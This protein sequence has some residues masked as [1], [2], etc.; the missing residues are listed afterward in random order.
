[1]KFQKK[2]G[3]KSVYILNSAKEINSILA[4]LN[5]SGVRSLSLCEV[6]KKKYK[7]MKV[8]YFVKSSLGYITGLKYFDIEFPTYSFGDIQGTNDLLIFNIENDMME[9]FTL[10]NKKP[11]KNVLKGLFI[12]GA[13]FE[14]MEQ[15]KTEST[16][17]N[18][19]SSEFPIL[20]K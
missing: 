18:I 1:M 15:I 7:S 19:N 16:I 9:I 6:D 14:F 20:E 13:I 2:Q 8:E 4:P 11:F 17:I 5:N 10:K 12:D 3:T